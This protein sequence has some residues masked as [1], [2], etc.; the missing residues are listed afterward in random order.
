M[1]YRNYL[2]KYKGT[3][4][5]RPELDKE[6]HDFPRNHKD[7]IDESY[8]DIYIDCKNGNRIYYY[9]RCANVSGVLLWAYIPSIIRGRSIIRQMNV[10]SIPYYAYFETDEEVTFR[11]KPNNID[12]VASLLNARTYGANI[13]PFSP[14]NLPKSEISI[15]EKDLTLYK[16]I[17]A[18]LD[19]ND[20]LIIKRF[21]DDFCSKILSKTMRQRDKSYNFSTDIK[22]NK[23]S[24]SV[25]TYI[26]KMGFWDE[27]IDY[28]H[29]KIKTY[30]KNK[31]KD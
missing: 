20:Y 28:L 8:D 19:K 3:Y 23:M 25:K 4:R 2:M 21:T 31:N 18:S 17:T 24:R 13:S 12:D 29:K 6:T 15:D 9:G 1:G 10:L 22:K 26:W 16:E 11:F 27:Y 14:R 5:L 30:Y 7:E